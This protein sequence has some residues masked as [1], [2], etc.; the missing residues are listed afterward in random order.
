[1]AKIWQTLSSE[2]KSAIRSRTRRF[3]EDDLDDRFVQKD[4]V[5]VFK[6]MIKTDQSLAG[7]LDMDL[8]EEGEL[9]PEF[10]SAEIDAVERV[11]E[12][13]IMEVALISPEDFD[14]EPEISAEEEKAAR[15]IDKGLADVVPYF[16]EDLMMAGDMASAEAETAGLPAL[17]DHRPDQSSIKNQGSRGT[18][19][20]HASLALLE[21]YQHIPDDLSEQCTHYKFNEFLNRP[22]NV[23]SGLRTTDA[24]GLLARNDGRICTE[25]D[26]PYI[27][28]QGTINQLVANG[29]YAPPQACQNNDSYGYAS[30]GY[31]IITD[32]GLT[33]ESI[34]NTRY[35]EALLYKGYNIVIGTWVSWDDKD[36]DGILDPVL[37]NNGNPIGRGGHAMLVVG[38]DRNQQFF[39]V[40]NSW[41]SGWG[42]N[43]YAYF[44]YDLVRTCFKYGFIVDKIQPPAPAQGLSRKLS[45]APYSSQKISRAKLRAAILVMRTS[46]GR[47]AV[48]EAYAGY[49]LHLRNLKVFDRDGNLHLERDS[50][51]VRGTYLVDID[52]AKETSLDADF[53][54]EAVRPG[55][56]NLVPR[57]GA[58][59]WVA[60][61]F[62]GFSA[63]R[64][65]HTNLGSAAIRYEDLNYAVVVGKTTA[66]RRFKLLAHIK[67]GNKLQISYLVIYKADGSGHDYA[68]I[69]SVRSSWT[70]NLDTKTKGGGR[71]ADIWNHAISDGVGFM[72][73]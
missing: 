30:N 39:I 16:K 37:D 44:S 50:L 64:I 28:A 9:T 42:H 63:T 45:Q 56:N 35:L 58:A 57:N 41:G 1:M 54:W 49:N 46:K 66:N 5:I 51:V 12:F 8:P 4:D 65:S 15:S 24:A 40:K 52:L 7:K 55:V 73:K 69:L 32:Q 67:P 43:G 33:G 34:K 17:V 3:S 48:C 38:Y 47:Y 13:E 70:Y 68:R 60:F 19:V 59:A 62:A 6:A 10:L 26:W 18:C 2:Q 21:A 71:Y 27:P 14:Y 23:N 31:K 61:D 11:E 72:E 22:H 29:T 25:N 53:W 36:N 20:A